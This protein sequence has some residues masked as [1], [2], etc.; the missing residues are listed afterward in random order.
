MWVAET[1][2][3]E[4]PPTVSSGGWQ[5]EAGIDKG[6]RT[7]IQEPPKGTSQ[8]LTPEFLNSCLDSVIWSPEEL[9]G[10][11]LKGSYLKFMI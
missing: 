5:Q 4:L 1:Q 11:G 6:G 9:C 10:E 7:Q 2:A 3:A 8:T